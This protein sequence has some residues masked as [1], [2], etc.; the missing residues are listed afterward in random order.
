MKVSPD[1]ASL[2]P[3]VPGK[4]IETLRRELGLSGRIIKLASNEN[5]L[6]ASKAAQAAIRASVGKIFRYPDGAGHRLVAALA[7]KWGVSTDQVILGHGSDEVIELLVRTFLQSGDEAVMADPTFSCYRLMVTAG[8]GKPVT[9]PLVD[10]R[11][12]LAAMARAITPKCRLVFVCNPNNPTGTI[13]DEAEVERFLARVPKRVL[14]VFDEA[15]AEY[16]TAPTFPKMVRRVKGGDNV[17]FLRT[18]SKI[19]GLAGM[20]IGY[21]IGSADVVGP[22]NR[23]RQPFNTG[24]LAQEA[25]LAALADTQHVAKSLALNQAGMADLT[26]QFDAL[27]IGYFP[28]QANFIHFHLDGPEQVGAEVYDAL[29]HHGIIIRHM[30]GRN[31]RVTIGRPTENRRFIRALKTVLQEGRKNT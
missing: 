24:L 9:V 8:H 27:G 6:G 29:L 1:V 26:R 19:Y 11:H 5:P 14:V 10:G 3:Y 17:I 30:G 12:S 2:D 21:G 25:A 4:P 13:V 15:Y 31:L 7:K 16:V 20:R 23:V 18:F 22:L 28:S